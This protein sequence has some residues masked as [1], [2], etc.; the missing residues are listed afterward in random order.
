MKKPFGV[1][2]TTNRITQIIVMAY[3]AV[4]V[5]AFIIFPIFA[6]KFFQRPFLGIF[7]EHTLVTN[8]VGPEGAPEWSLLNKGLRFGNK[9]I[10]L[11]FL[12]PDQTPI[13]TVEPKNYGDIDAFLYNH[14]PG[15]TVR[16]TFRARDGAETSYDVDLSSFPLQYQT[17]YFYLPYVIGLVYLGFGL[18]IFGLR[19]EETAGRAFSLFTTSVALVSGGLLDLYTTHYL[20]RL[21]V[22][23]VPLVGSAFFHL[24]LVFPQ[25][26]RISLRYPI[27]RWFW[28]IPAIFLGIVNLYTVENFREPTLYG[29]VWKYSYIFVGISTLFFIG[30]SFYRLFLSPSPVV[31]QQAR[32]ILIGV[33]ISFAPITSWLLLTALYT[34]NFNP[35]LFF[36][37]L[38]VFPATT[39]YTVLRYRLVRTDYL[40]G[41]A[42][43]YALLTLMA[44]GGY[45]FLAYGLSLISGTAI[46]P[47]NP[48]LLALF[49]F[50][51][52]FLLN[53]VRAW[54]QEIIDSIF[55]RGE[56]AHQAR[57][58]AFTHEI[59]S[60]T[61]QSS[62]LRI[63]REQIS[64]SLLPS[65]FHIYVYDS[66]NDQ[67]IA[68]S[69]EVGQVTSDIRF[70]AK[71]PLPE[72]L[73]KER[74]PLFV[75]ET[76]ILEALHSERARLSLLGAH[77]FIPMPGRERLAG[78]IALGERLSGESYASHDISFL[79]A[80]GDQ[81]A[82][83]FE[84]AQV[85]SNMER[86][87]NEM[88]A[89]ARVAQGINV[90]LNFDD[91][92][93]LIYA[94]SLQIMPGDDFH[95]ALYN[96]TGQYFYYAFCLENDDRIPQKE[97]LPL[98]SKSTLDQEVILTRRSILTQ[99]F[100]SQC[101]VMGV[102]SPARGLYAWLGVPL[103]TGSDT[104]GAL[105]I[106]SRDPNI[107]Y[108]SAQ[109]DLLQAIADQAAG[110]IVKSRL[111]QETERR[112]QQLS[113]LNVVARQLTQTLEPKHLLQSI[114]DNAVSIL[115]SEAGSL[116]TKDDQTD[117][118]IFEVTV[119]PGASNLIGQRLPPGTGSV[120]KA[121]TTRA[122][123]IVNEVQSSTSWSPSIDKQ[124]GFVTKAILAV[125]M[126]VKDRV[127]GVIEIINKKDGLPFT[128]DDKNLLSAFAGQAAV[129]LENA[130]LYNQTDKELTA[131][132]EELSVM[133]RIDRELN[134]SLE[135]N[136]AMRIT[137]EWAMRQ[138]QAEAGAIG[139]V[140]E[141]GVLLVAQQGYGDQLEKYKEEYLPLDHPAVGEAIATGQPRRVVFD[142]PDPAHTFLGEAHSQLVIPIRR[143]AHVIGLFLLESTKA[144]SFQQDALNFLS[145][146]SDHAA[147]AIANAQLYAEVQAANVAKSEFVSFVAHELKNPMTSIKGYAELLAAGAVG[148]ITDMQGSFLGTIRGNIERMKTIVEDL[149]DNA[150]IEAGRLRLDFK[151]VEVPDI[152]ETV[153][154]S[155]KRQIEDKKQSV[156]V[157]M[158]E[159][160]PKIW[161]D[162]TRIEQVLVNLVSNSH[163]YTQ[164]GGNILVSAEKSDNLWDP[165]GA[166]E[167][168]HIAVQDNGIGLTPEDQKKIFQRFFRSE[169]DQARKSPGTGLGLNITRSLIEMQGGRI[170][171]E[172]E[173]RKGTTF[174]FTVPISEN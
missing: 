93:E 91:I 14:F 107:T 17:Q 18:G 142:L 166:A 66:L 85:V 133:Q 109:M 92:L 34:M 47:G 155:T 31:R 61:D 135:V 96:K 94:Q 111:L 102:T 157:K 80:L 144:D 154:R 33:L 137:L 70:T 83:A 53:P 169:D 120:G 63:L 124:T 21:W 147:I 152:V 64:V 52:A 163:K 150:K 87:V 99:D 134:A 13:A 62:I 168:V 84:R 104:I 138:S 100:F 77:L 171:F 37:P 151:A 106:A 97:N 42:V 46:G 122:P 9:L 19:R 95:L 72:T 49:V 146:L 158:P 71:G 39:G 55:F 73:R 173:F 108:T 74:M 114:L 50:L 127:I 170:W 160:L 11:S 26:A 65:Q 161:G 38:V 27:L 12:G 28:Y 78:W 88:N 76:H 48:I 5:A 115:N 60:A 113:I 98:P 119:G 149:N 139:F 68:T 32:T 79:E 58:K 69:D 105:S 59:T 125:P 86:R 25:E 162:R 1:G 143:E 8:G 148:P 54:L 43:L 90:T 81:A 164:E 30:T 174:H 129:A 156:E 51:S 56:R 167:V 101:Q 140:H 117:E 7:V 141:K 36:V 20:S 103:N 41:R 89:L 75:N 22:V 57:L 145:R 29:D 126:E 3:Q 23:A 40:M 116:F 110:A 131:R 44:L 165:Q 10:S 123:V 82:M 136:R 118:L 35:Y 15:E 16:A 45:V 130:R 112:A 2:L 159:N 24:A 121:V 6:V 4:A 172:S 132:V 67:Y 153:I 128:D